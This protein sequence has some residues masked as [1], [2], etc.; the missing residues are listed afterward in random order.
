MADES[1][2]LEVVV[3]EIDDHGLCLVNQVCFIQILEPRVPEV[4]TS[5]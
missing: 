5:I 1:E 2:T 4:E 3:S